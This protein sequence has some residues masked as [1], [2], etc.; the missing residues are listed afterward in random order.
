M[1]PFEGILRLVFTDLLLC[2]KFGQILCLAIETHSQEFITLASNERPTLGTHVITIAFTTVRDHFYRQRLLTLF[3]EISAQESDKVQFY[4]PDHLCHALR[5]LIEMAE[6]LIDLFTGKFA[7][8]LLCASQIGFELAGNSSQQFGSDVLAKLPSGFDCFDEILMRTRLLDFY[9]HFH[10]YQNQ[11]DAHVI[12]VLKENFDS[13]KKVFRSSVIFAYSYLYTRT[14]DDN[15]YGKNFMWFSNCRKWIQFLTISD[16]GAIHLTHL[17]Y[18][19]FIFSLF[20]FPSAQL[21]SSNDCQALSFHS[22]C[23][24]SGG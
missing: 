2:H 6:L 18:A 7:D 14:G 10:F 5:R 11:T 22:Q 1:I 15:F 20:L 4:Q 13:A 24:V 23:K 3:I 17:K 9:L 12:V 21:N 8:G 19:L 16:V